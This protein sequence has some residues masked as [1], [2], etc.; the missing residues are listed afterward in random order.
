MEKKLEYKILVY[1]ENIICFN[2]LDN[3]QKH[4]KVNI[5]WVFGNRSK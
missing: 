2:N 3:F 1:I 4:S 5:G